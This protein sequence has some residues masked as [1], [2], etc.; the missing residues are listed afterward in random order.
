MTKPEDRQEARSPESADP[1]LT[2]CPICKQPVEAGSPRYP[3][4]SKRC[5]QIDLGKWLN[6]D[7][8][9]S[10]PLDASDLDDDAH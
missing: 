10:R 4:C 2:P 9:I 7:Y 6:A 3:F 8:V 1:S 5:R